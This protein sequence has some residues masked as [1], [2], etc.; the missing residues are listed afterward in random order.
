M[1]LLFTSL[2]ITDHTRFDN[3]ISSRPILRREDVFSSVYLWRNFVQQQVAWST[4][5]AI[6]TN[7]LEDNQ[8]YFTYITNN[9]ELIPQI[10]EEVKTYCQEKELP[11][12]FFGIP[13]EDL[14]YFQDQQITFDRDHSDYIY[15]SAVLA[16]L[17][18][19]KFHGKRNFITRFTS[20]YRSEV[21]PYTPKDD[22][23]ILELYHTWIMQN[24]GD[25][26]YSEM[27]QLQEAIRFRQELQ[28]DITVLYVDEHLIG[29]SFID[30]SHSMAL[31]LFEKCNINFVGAYQYINQIEAQKLVGRCPHL[32]REDD[33]GLPSLRQSKLSYY[34]ALI[35]EKYYIVIK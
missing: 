33:W 35:L 11:C 7:V 18:G 17:T 2:L 29:F 13:T 10:I 24:E 34:P 9:Q 26:I 27:E 15:E 31:T 8:I 4:N 5:Y 30:I 1:S 19:K 23:A 14:V 20:T 6:F 16:N 32:N 22:W 3:C 21:R 25:H 12:Q 28:L